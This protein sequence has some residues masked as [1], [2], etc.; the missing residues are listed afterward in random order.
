MFRRLFSIVSF[1]SVLNVKAL[2]GTFNQEEVL[3]WAF[4]MIVK[5]DCETDGSFAAL[6]E[7]LFPARRQSWSAAAGRY[8]NGMMMHGEK[9]DWILIPL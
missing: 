8:G 2:V 5:T 3:V 6:V 7:T 9:L 1:N 4:S